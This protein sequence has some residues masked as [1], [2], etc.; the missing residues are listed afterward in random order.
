MFY[1]C[2]QYILT[3]LKIV[4]YS[5]LALFRFCVLRFYYLHFLKNVHYNAFVYFKFSCVTFPVII[6]ITLYMQR[7][8]IEEERET[9][10]EKRDIR[11]GKERKVG[12]EI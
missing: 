10:K 4:T 3:V 6:N 9:M 8:K 12:R 7:K 1:G 2:L 5:D 11:R